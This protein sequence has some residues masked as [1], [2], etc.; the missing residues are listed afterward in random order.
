MSLVGKFYDPI[1][2]LAPVTIRFKMLFQKLC[3]DKMEW[4]CPLP[5]DLLQEWKE[6]ITDLGEGVP[7]SVPRSYLHGVS[8]DLVSVT[9]CGFCDASTRAYAAV[10]Y[11]VLRTNSGAAVRF[12]VSKTRVAPLQLQTIP[13]LELL[14]A[15]LLSKLVVS[16]VNSLKSTLPP[17]EIRC[18]T[19]SQV[20]LYW[21]QGIH[22]EWKP[23]VEDR[24]NEIRRNVN[25]NL[26]SHCP[27]S[28]N[29]ADLPSR[30]LNALEVSVNQLWRQGLEWLYARV[31]PCAETNPLSTMPE[32]CTMELR[33]CSVHAITLVTTISK[34]LVSELIDC[35]SFS[36][37]AKLLRVT[38]LVLQA[39]E[40]FKRTVRVI[41]MS[42]PPG[43]S[44]QQQS[45]SG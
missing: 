24:V 29:P 12:V 13:R 17:V 16:V 2:F 40:K 41:L 27:G 26:W 11:L 45:Y 10:V 18:Y 22:K 9:L 5:E 8:E 35:K 15:L 30:G 19:D 4:D 34:P 36:K 28:S 39:V 3:R 37:L 21:I 20:A 43:L 25:P 7:V 44:C 31:E 6:L 33:K 14:S 23:F 1:G 38:A 32:E 42:V